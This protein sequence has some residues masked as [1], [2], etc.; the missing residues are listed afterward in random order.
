M[1][2]PSVR[3]ATT[4]KGVIHANEIDGPTIANV[5]VA[6]AASGVANSGTSDD[7]GRFELKFP[8]KNPG[9]MVEL[10][11]FKR[12][13]TVVNSFDMRLA[14]PA[15]PD[16]ELLKVILAKEA[17]R[18]EMV[19]RL[20]RLKSFDFIENTYNEKLKTLED[21]NRAT[22]A[23]LSK[24]REE[25]NQAK[26]LAE[27][28]AEEIAKLP[29]PSSEVFQQ[30][31]SLFLAG[32]IEEALRLLDAEKENLR[33]SIA[34]AR[35]QKEDAEQAIAQSVKTYILDAQLLTTSFRFKEAEASY[36]ELI[37]NAPDSFEAQFAFAEFNVALNRFSEAQGAYE[38]AL[39]LAPTPA[40]AAKTRSNLGLVYFRRNRLDKARQ[41]YSRA[42]VTYRALARQNREADLA[43]FANTLNRMG[44]L[45]RR[46][47][48]FDKALKA[49]EDALAIAR[50]L[51]E[52]N[53]EINLPLLGV[54]LNSL[55]I[56]N[57]D[58]LRLKEARAGF[59]ENLKISQDLALR[60]PNVYLSYVARTFNN[61]GLL[62][63][64]ENRLDKARS[65]FEE[66]L[67]IYG[68][69]EQ[70]NPEGYIPFVAMVLNNLGFVLVDQD[71]LGEA[72]V[73]LDDALKIFRELVKLDSLKPYQRELGEV[74]NNLG[75]L[76]RR[77]MQFEL[78]SLSY[79]EALAMRRELAQQEKE[80]LVLVA[81]TLNEM[82]SL[83]R[84]R[85]Q[86]DEACRSYDEALKIRRDFAGRH[87]EAYNSLVAET[88][89]NL[90]VV[91]S[92]LKKMK[93]AYHAFDE[94]LKIRRD[95]MKL[96][97]EAFMPSVAETL[98]NL[99]TLFR[100]Q[101]QGRKA[102]KALEEA[103]EIYGQLVRNNYLQYKDDMEAVAQALRE[104]PRR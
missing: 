88:V 45:L 73:K 3:A 30:A 17:D 77:Q 67:A 83:Y 22:R 51:A 78:S 40:S 10:V 41:A 25:Y 50:D 56:L 81:E 97:R 92:D 43:D 4:L 98:Y 79:K 72:R 66:A 101:G 35:R 95:L 14:L 76:Y 69:L 23:E 36:R 6:V 9:D 8:Q 39:K 90:G 38:K 44:G 82:G 75:T 70:Q 1:V 80:A 63:Y 16:A 27:K 31:M 20:L 13:Y 15:D 89:N 58:Q 86:L 12:G 29:D 99:G 57:Y 54:A 65:A 19:R 94:A 93:E 55:A 28:G 64:K 53:R 62:H 46:Q 60:D 103:S 2:A 47:G 21:E 52:K 102:R 74:L 104:L 32:K 5:E 84:N 61:L 24:L 71:E 87:W 85:R 26:R 11:I 91:Y 34:E 100:D 42:L 18:E 7:K 37:A 96:Q 49:Y 48:E 59:E 68:R 33:K